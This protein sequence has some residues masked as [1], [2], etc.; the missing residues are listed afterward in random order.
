MTAAD[1]LERR[2]EVLARLASWYKVHADRAAGSRAAA[3]CASARD[4]QEE[5]LRTAMA[6]ASAAR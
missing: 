1:R 2:A 3:L 5:A 4:M 6:A